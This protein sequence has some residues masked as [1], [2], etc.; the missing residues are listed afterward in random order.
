MERI[1]VSVRD[2]SLPIGLWR[3]GWRTMADERLGSGVLLLVSF[4]LQLGV[5]I[6]DCIA[7]DRD[8]RPLT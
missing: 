7:D 1:A 4:E 5:R 8:E 2:F 6:V 3:D